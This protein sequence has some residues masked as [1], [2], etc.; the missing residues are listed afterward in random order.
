MKLDYKEIF[1]HQPCNCV[2]IY[3]QKLIFKYNAKLNQD[4]LL[5]SPKSNRIM[6]MQ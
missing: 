1:S 2:L 5:F 6:Q 4:L 3:F